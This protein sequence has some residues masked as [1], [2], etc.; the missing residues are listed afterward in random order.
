MNAGSGDGPLQGSKP[1]ARPAPEIIDLVRRLPLSQAAKLLEPLSS[2]NLLGLL[3]ALL[4]I[5]RNRLEQ[6]LSRSDISFLIDEKLEHRS[7][8]RH[9]RLPELAGS[10]EELAEIFAALLANEN[11]N[12][13][14]FRHAQMTSKLADSLPLGSRVHFLTKLLTSLTTEPRKQWIRKD[15]GGLF[16]IYIDAADAAF[17]HR[18]PEEA[19]D[20][21]G[22]ARKIAWTLPDSRLSAKA[23]FRCLIRF[24][25]ALAYLPAARVGELHAEAHVDLQRELENVLGYDPEDGRLLRLQAALTRSNLWMAGAAKKKLWGQITA[26][27]KRIEILIDAMRRAYGSVFPD[28]FAAIGIIHPAATDV[29]QSERSAIGRVL[30]DLAQSYVRLG[31][32]QRSA[33]Y[34]VQSQRYDLSPRSRLDADIA[35]AT[36]SGDVTVVVRLCETFARDHVYD[37]LGSMSVHH[38][39]RALREYSNAARR[40]S[41]ILKANNYLVSSAFWKRQARYWKEE[42]VAQQS[43]WGMRGD[44]ATQAPLDES[45]VV[46]YI[47]HVLQVSAG[48]ERRA[49][50][51]SGSLS[52][53]RERQRIRARKRN[54]TRDRQEPDI[55]DQVRDDDELERDF[56]VLTP[57]GAVFPSPEAE[58]AR[59]VHSAVI[60]GL[61]KVSRYVAEENVSEIVTMLANT[62]QSPNLPVDEPLIQ[63]VTEAI[64]AIVSWKPGDF[65]DIKALIDD[66]RVDR[67]NA[68]SIAL[69][70]AVA[71]A[72][73]FAP[74]RLAPVLLTL[75]YSFSL[76]VMEQYELASEALQVARSQGRPLYELRAFRRQLE[77]HEPFHVTENDESVMGRLS[78]ILENSNDSMA[79]FGISGVFDFAIGVARELADISE[80][81]AERRRVRLAFWASTLAQGWTTAALAQAPEAVTELNDALKVRAVDD[82]ASKRRL[83]ST[84]L[85]RICGPGGGPALDLPSPSIVLTPD[86]A[87]VTT[88]R[89]LRSSSKRIWAL[90]QADAST[91]FAVPLEVTAAE[92][93]DLSDAVWFW[94]R[95]SKASGEDADVFRRLYQACVAP[96]AAHVEPAKQ[97]TFAFHQGVP[98]LPVHGAL[99]PTGF[100]GEKVPINYEISSRQASWRGDDGWIAGNPAA[101]LGWDPTTMS[102]VEAT[103]I[104][105]LLNE[106][107]EIKGAESASAARV[108]LILNA[109]LFLCILHVAGHGHLLTNPN[110]MESSIEL[111]PNVSVTALDMLRSGCR[112]QFIFLNVCGIGNSEA[113]AG[114]AYG[115]ALAARARGA[116][117]FIAPTTYVSPGDARAF[118]NLFYR[119]ALGNDT[120]TAAH[121]ATRQLI[122]NGAPPAAWMP[123]AVF[124]NLGP[125]TSLAARNPG[126]P[127]D[128]GAT[129]RRVAF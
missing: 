79:A 84:I 68:V 94:L 109:N 93:A 98:F 124:G 128:S 42:S 28:D 74:Y 72:R 60:E 88:V 53:S 37:Q 51:A 125:L 24:C 78:R 80:V 43:L 4:S 106:I 19:F 5:D 21:C 48:L 35:L 126:L 12:G 103:E 40:L 86:D 71:L 47:D 105:A 117:A 62:G 73:K 110:A 52:R 50:T 129:A 30:V 89:Y 114:D 11:R 116:R 81:L 29:P 118:A 63:A 8:A 64:A 38:L 13:I 1:H 108:D 41:N 58:H 25:T 91:H 96:V 75:S 97:L 15:S 120:V 20:L 121:F 107:C 122:V 92:L 61:G 83:Y 57:G 102:D 32:D 6:L 115:F 127:A 95:A 3:I 112:S 55:D 10:F 119:A 70:A 34:I 82:T 2:Q 39:T 54:R 90:G 16:Y 7:L 67:T 59:F 100:L 69:R 44:R 123:Y 104:S 101:V 17:K 77:L 27:E 66:G 31:D 65:A 85:S 23:R 46:G 14:T 99:G 87:G 33:W 56:A 45:Q 26:A 113:T 76:E 36:S 22:E 9:V 49:E 111:D 18:L